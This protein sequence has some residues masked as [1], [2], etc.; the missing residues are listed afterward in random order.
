MGRIVIFL[1]VALLIIGGGYAWWVNGIAPVNSEDR[2]EKIFVIE[3]GSGI[4]EIANRLSQE[5][6]VKDPIV[7][8]LY[9]KKERKDTA[10]QAGDYRLSP[11]MDV[12]ALV[13]TLSH[14]TLD[15]WV[16]FPEGLR[17]EEVTE[18]VKKN[19]AGYTDSWQES[20]IN[21]TGYLFPDTYLIPKNAT[22]EQIVSLMRENFIKKI[23]SI[24]LRQDSS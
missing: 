6:L 17:G 18:I 10:I 9:I 2:S 20:F 14:G 19:F 21:N 13:K 1:V 23:G 24:G 4:R 12:E 16:T 3:K 5:G 15:L 22:D 11:S 7:F 8:F